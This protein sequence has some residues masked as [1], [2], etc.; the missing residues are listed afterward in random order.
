MMLMMFGNNI[1]GVDDVTGEKVYDYEDKPPPP[2]TSH[3]P[4]FFFFPL[5]IVHLTLRLGIAPVEREGGMLDVDG[6]LLGFA[7]KCMSEDT[8]AYWHSW[9]L[10]PSSNTK[11]GIQEPTTSCTQLL[12]IIGHMCPPTLICC[13]F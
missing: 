5:D 1:D 2:F 11:E 7:S 10:T 6:L 13:V 9:V 8:H 3:S 4:A 12:C